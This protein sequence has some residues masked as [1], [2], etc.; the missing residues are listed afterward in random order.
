[1]PRFTI[2]YTHGSDRP[3]PVYALTGWKA[4]GHD[5]ATRTAL[6]FVST[7]LARL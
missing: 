3:R 7:D 1:M 4:E 6:C 2:L 5:D